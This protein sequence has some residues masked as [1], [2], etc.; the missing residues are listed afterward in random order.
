[1]ATYEIEG[2]DDKQLK[3]KTWQWGRRN[4]I[5]KVFIG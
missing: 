2:V 3:K 1:M 5:T 4:R